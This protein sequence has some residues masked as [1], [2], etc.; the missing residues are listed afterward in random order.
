MVPKR[1]RC[2]SVT[3]S[4]RLE[5]RSLIMATMAFFFVILPVI[6]FAI[7]ATG[8]S[9]AAY[10]RRRRGLDTTTRTGLPPSPA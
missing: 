9:I 8:I 5:T 4:F 2:A 1:S 7:L 6:L 3:T 10:R